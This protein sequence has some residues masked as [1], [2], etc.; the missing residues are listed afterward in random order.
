MA[1][2][3][4]ALEALTGPGGQEAF[5]KVIAEDRAM[6]KAA[7]DNAKQ[8][9][10][11]TPRLAQNAYNAAKQAN[12]PT[13]KPQ[14]ERA[15]TNDEQQPDLSMPDLD[16]TYAPVED[17]R[18]LAGTA[19]PELPAGYREDWS[20]ELESEFLRWTIAEKIPA[21]TAQRLLDYYT[22]MSITRAGGDVQA[23]VE[24]FHRTFK[25]LTQEQRDLL[26]RF[27]TLDILGNR[28]SE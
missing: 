19:Q 4:G 7:F 23:V 17:L 20:T 9:E 8:P 13:T 28:S 27:W 14:P 18:R 25:T 5:D 10:P 12:A 22:E 16:L 24:D 26:L 15:P 1:L 3:A 2:P 6:T 21:G 11:T